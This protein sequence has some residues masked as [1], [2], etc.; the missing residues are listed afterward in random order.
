MVEA[1]KKY[2]GIDFD[3]IET[4]EEA[5]ALAKEKVLSLKSVT[6]EAISSISSLRSL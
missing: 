3:Q 6:Q 2:S 1:I 5:K 4:T